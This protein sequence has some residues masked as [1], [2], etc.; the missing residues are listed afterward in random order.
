[1]NTLAPSPEPDHAA[2]FE[3]LSRV[4]LLEPAFDAMPDTASFVKD[5]RARYTLHGASLN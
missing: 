2:L 5:V 1:M 4:R 3:M